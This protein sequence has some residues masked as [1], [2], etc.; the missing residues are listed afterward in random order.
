[1][2]ILIVNNYFR[3][4]GD[5]ALL[6]VLIKQVRA[7]WPGADM[8]LASLEQPATFP[9]FDGATNVGSIRLYSGDADISRPR[10]LARKALVVA[11]S[12][13]WGRL[14]APARRVTTR[15][16]PRG[17]AA[18]LAAI[19]AA[20]LVLSASGGYM[21]ATNSL[22]GNLNI[23]HLLLPLKLAR[24]IGKPV[25]MA[26]QSFG[27]FGNAWQR[28]TVARTLDRLQHSFVREDKS[29]RLLA[30]QGVNPGLLS[31]AID[32][33]FAFDTNVAS[34]TPTLQPQPRIGITARTWL[35]GTA[36][37]AYEQGIA[38]TIA[39]VSAGHH[40][41]FSLIPQVTSELYEDDD[42]VPERRIA[43]FARALG[44]PVEQIDRHLSHHD[45]KQ[46]YAGLDATIGTRFHSVI[47]SLTS[48]VPAIAIEYE[49]KTSGI[50]HD[51]GLEDWVIKI[52]DVTTP[53]LTA[54]LERLL[55]EHDA[56]VRHLRAV[57]P[58]Y[59]ARTNTTGPLMK[60]I[61]EHSHTGRLS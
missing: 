26:P 49:H 25:I 20:D 17:L 52:G 7:E 15:R 36:Q 27:P 12:L 5:A 29:L 32:S 44:A 30:E 39:A 1:M 61:Y 18:E 55:Q 42:R 16:L 47:F 34:Q 51:L 45:V 40:A 50:M 4:T 53:R 31:R 8:T 19:A 56:Y 33:G 2:K 13:A 43:E 6:N 3:N 48:Y 37:T 21:N 22:G 9:T 57:M 58:D 24:Q 46:L 54:M 59:I 60:Q 28:R 41:K 10:R 11:V 14:S 38:G 35:P 23:W